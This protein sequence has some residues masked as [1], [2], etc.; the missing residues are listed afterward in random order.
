MARK[1]LKDVTVSHSVTSA[2]MGH[3]VSWTH[4]DDPLNA[5]R[6]IKEWHKA[7]LDPDDL[8][9]VRTSADLFMAACRSVETPKRSNAPEQVVVNRV[10]LTSDVVVYQ[11]TRLVRDTSVE[12]ITHHESMTLR[13]T[14][15]DEQI[16]VLEM[17]DYASLQ[18][19]EA[20]VR[21]HYAKH[22]KDIPGP[23]IRNTI[24]DLIER[25]GGQ[26]LRRR[27][28]GLYFV[29]LTHRTIDAQN[30]AIDVDNQPTLDGLE[31]FFDAMWDGHGDFYAW[32]VLS[33][34][35]DKQIVA[36]HFAL[37]VS[38]EL[39]KQMEDAVQRVRKGKGAGVQETLLTRLYNE[40][41]RLAGQIDVFDQLVTLERTDIDADLRDLDNALT[42]LRDLADS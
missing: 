13:F 5:T 35:K 27:A 1:N 33:R 42:A 9:D 12:E 37:N 25:L 40:R 30:R 24:R 7:G 23:K 28:G 14:K 20:D 34:E 6:V 41:R 8:P 11:L 17:A 2:T 39:R 26:N 15:D 29:P 36:K 19:L 18:G 16:T 10:K 31:A 32:P 21:A 22:T 3:L 38:K 4:P